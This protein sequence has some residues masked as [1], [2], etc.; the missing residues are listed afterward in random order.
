MEKHKHSKQASKTVKK[1]SPLQLDFVRVSGRFRVLKL[2]GSGGSGTT[3][4]WLGLTF[5]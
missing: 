5:F 4:L 2:L 3:Q 1:D